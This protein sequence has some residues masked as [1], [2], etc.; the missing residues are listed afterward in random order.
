MQGMKDNQPLVS[1]VIA[2]YNMGQFLPQAVD[3]V[4]NQT[5]SH[6]EVI[7][8]DDGS[9]DNTPEVMS[10]YEGDERI[11]YIRNKNEGQ[12]KA[13]NCGIRHTRGDFIAFCDADDLWEP[14]KLSVQMPLFNDP[15]IGVVYS[16]IGNIDEIGYRYE[17]SPVYDRHSGMVT[18]HL[19]RKNFVPFGTAVIRRACVEKNGVFDEQFR[20]GIDWDLWLRYSLDWKFAYTPERTYVYR[21]WSGQ[22]S[23]NYRGRFEHAIRI[24]RHFVEQHQDSLDPKALKT[25]WA[26]TYVNQASAIAINEGRIWE[27]FKGYLKGLWA[28][29]TYWHGWKSMIK[30]VL[31]R[32]RKPHG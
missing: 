9:K 31:G 28:D 21:E 5:W 2:S 11:T 19:L 23:T 6:L 27:P 29:P 12:P 4:L 1:V 8:V 20:M 18:R 17:C 32:Q 26:D 3:S 24:L 30:W 16:E 25:A 10:L 14:F 13:K 22:M 7:V 15:D